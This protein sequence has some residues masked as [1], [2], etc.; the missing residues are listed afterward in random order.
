MRSWH[1]SARIPASGWITEIAL[2]LR[3]TRTHR[4][5][6]LRFLRDAVIG[7]N[8]GMRKALVFIVALTLAADAQRIDTQKADSQKVVTGIHSPESPERHRTG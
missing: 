7:G 5:T 3:D 8:L 6:H 1:G 2:V 4:Q